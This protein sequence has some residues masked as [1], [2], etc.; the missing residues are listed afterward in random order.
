VATFYE[1]DDEFWCFVKEFI[2]L[3][4]CPSTAE[5]DFAG[6]KAVS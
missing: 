1:H 2:E 3:L 6:Y 4:V 5:E